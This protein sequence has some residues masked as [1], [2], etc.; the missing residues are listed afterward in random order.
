MAYHIFITSLTEVFH[1]I[2][3]KKLTDK[4]EVTVRFNEVDSM[5]IVWHGNYVKFM[6][7]GR[8]SFGRKHGLGYLDVYRNETMTPIV[9]IEVDYKNKVEYGEKVI[10]ETT[11]HNTETAKIEL[12][13][14]IRRSSDNKIAATGR[15]VQVFV[16][17]N[18]ELLLYPPQFYLDWKKSVGLID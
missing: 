7:D 2:V 12:S 1:N 4:T 3:S 10:V 9:K 13:Y 5:Q 6:E 17:L 14:V 18:H 15:S 8:E 11:Y 16:N